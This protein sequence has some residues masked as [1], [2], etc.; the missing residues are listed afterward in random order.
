MIAAP[1]PNPILPPARLGLLGGG[2]LGRMFA[3][4]ARTLGYEVWVLDP[5]PGAPAAHFASRH[6]CAGYTDE[7]ALAELAS[8]AAI[9][10]EFENPPAQSLA[11]LSARTLV[12]PGSEAV[13]IA[14]D[15]IRE[16]AFFRDNG[17]PVGNFAVIETAAELSLARAR[18][19]FP[20][21]FKTA[22]FGYDGK[23]QVRVESAADL[24]SAWASLR[25]SA[26][27]LEELLPLD[28]EI[29]IVLARGADGA[30]VQ[31]PIA[32]NR[33]RAG[34]L[35][36]SIV[37]AR[38]TPMQAE[39]ATRIASALA[40]A[41]RYVGVLG[42]EMFVVRGEVLLNE[43]APRPHNS[44]H[45]TLEATQTTQFEQQIRALCGLP[46]G[47]PALLQPVAMLNL[48][49]DIWPEVAVGAPPGTAPPWHAVFE[50]PGAHLHLYGKAS[51]R[52][53]RKMGHVTVL[54][55]GRDEVEAAVENI[56]THVSPR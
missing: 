55:A 21:I 26:G 28:K 30:I 43:M 29:S 53:G 52:P 47:S 12:R 51:P 35:D 6:I 50:V 27:I 23:G 20:A 45:F 46:L 2:Q 17:F 22:R 14:Q 5:D 16:K 44:G 33:H 11:W 4:R 54:G 48:L 36:V 15:R 56:R 7:A 32:E 25:H 24:E 49:G 31:F 40:H 13:A 19:R 34:V 3:E 41:L 10:T 8:C 1:L 9:T 39:E 18:V 38:V 42:V 37:P